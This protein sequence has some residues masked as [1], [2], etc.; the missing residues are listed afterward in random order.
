MALYSKSLDGPWSTLEVPMRGGVVAGASSGCTNPAAAL[1]KNGT[2][3][4]VCKVSSNVQKWRQMAVYTAP[5][6][7]GP[8][9]FRR[10]TPVYG[11]DP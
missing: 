7:R 5:H 10:L 1:L 4:L 8:Y 11:E 2:V 9:D 3:L 6:W